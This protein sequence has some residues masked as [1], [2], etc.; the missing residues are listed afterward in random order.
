TENRTLNRALAPRALSR[1]NRGPEPA[2]PRST[3][4]AAPPRLGDEWPEPA[5]RPA[6]LAGD[7]PMILDQ[8]NY[9]NLLIPLNKFYDL[10][11]G[12]PRRPVFF[13][14]AA[15]CPELL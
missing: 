4:S 7:Q 2:G 11:I 10:H 15:T 8:I 13:D 3:P 6:I 1:S 5:A 12:G 9:E 14:I